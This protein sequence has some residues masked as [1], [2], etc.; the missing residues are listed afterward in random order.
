MAEKELTL[1]WFITTHR[2]YWYSENQFME[3]NFNLM[4]KI[5]DKDLWPLS[6]NFPYRI[7]FCSEWSRCWNE[8]MCPFCAKIKRQKRYQE[9]N[10]VI[11]MK[12]YCEGKN[13]LF[14]LTLT[15]KTNKN[16]S[17]LKKK[18][19]KYLP[20]LNKKMKTDKSSI[21]YQ[22]DWFYAVIDKKFDKWKWNIHFHMIIKTKEEQNISFL[23]KNIKI[24]WE[25]ISKATV[26]HIKEIEWNTNE[27]RNQSIL[28][29]VNYFWKWDNKLSMEHRFQFVKT[30]Y[31]MPLFK[32]YGC[33]KTD[34]SFIRKT[35][36]YKTIYEVNA[37][38]ISKK[39]KLI[40][41]KLLQVI[42]K[43][44]KDWIKKIWYIGQKLIF[45][46]DKWQNYLNCFP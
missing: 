27:T 16:L 35:R 7:W 18:A 30:F 44:F 34:L 28:T 42:I 2:K 6:S 41:V 14:F 37:F 43:L 10:K 15:L 24:E 33:F 36:Q 22:F 17:L 23:R 9:Y 5:K 13:R 1:S 32:N 39:I 31:D 45:I 19:E 46:K 26:I 38:S 3:Y 29:L 4:N 8:R 40:L 21:F 20:M 25:S 12:N 11:T